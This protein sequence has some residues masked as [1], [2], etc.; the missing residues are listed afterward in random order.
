MDRGAHPVRGEG[1]LSAI[2]IPVEYI[3]FPLK[4]K[5]PPGP[6]SD[7]IGIGPG[8]Q[9]NVRPP[10][11]NP[12][13]SLADTLGLIVLLFPVAHYGKHLKG[14]L[15]LEPELGRLKARDI[16][17]NP[18]LDQFPLGTNPNGLGHQ[19][20]PTPLYDDSAMKR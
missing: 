4:V 10:A 13:P 20:V 11:T 2:H 3:P 6:V 1:P 14:L 12:G 19:E 5:L 17:Q 7:L 18:P 16:P 8:F 15:R 9:E